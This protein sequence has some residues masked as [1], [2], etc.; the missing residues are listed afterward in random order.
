M[1]SLMILLAWIALGLAS[2]TFLRQP[3]EPRL[4]WAPMAIVFGPMWA[5]IALERG[6]PALRAPKETRVE[7]T[8][9]RRQNVA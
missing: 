6:A 3:G 8:R 7:V 1:A 9:P 4:A 2:C 5:V